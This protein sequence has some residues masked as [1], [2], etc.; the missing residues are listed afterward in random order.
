LIIIK[1]YF[2]IL[3]NF[4]K[5]LEFPANLVLILLKFD[6]QLAKIND[7]YKT[8]YKNH[9]ENDERHIKSWEMYFKLYEKLGAI[10]NK[11]KAEINEEGASIKFTQNTE[12][13]LYI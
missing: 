8:F 4:L 13:K 2:E 12:V 11:F 6:D 10:L 9:F 7:K 1:L 5:N 3:L